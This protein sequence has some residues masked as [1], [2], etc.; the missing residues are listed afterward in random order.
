M[1]H[2]ATQVKIEIF[3]IQTG[4]ATRYIL[5]TGI[6]E[7]FVRVECSEKL[8]EDG[9]WECP[10]EVEI[11]LSED[12][13]KCGQHVTPHPDENDDDIESFERYLMSSDSEGSP[14]SE[15]FKN[16]E[17][18]MDI[19]EDENAETSS[20]SLQKKGKSEIRA[21]LFD[22]NAKKYGKSLNKCRNC[23]FSTIL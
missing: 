1:A 2:T 10:N 11:T 15:L 8:L 16:F 18:L 3:N 17:R 22:K 20:P 4:Q 5:K 9:P 21:T 13:I 14:C 6:N 23:L 19:E 12:N 7:E